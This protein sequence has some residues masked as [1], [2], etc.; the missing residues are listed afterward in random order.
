M[1]LKSSYTGI[2]ILIKV[3]YIRFQLIFRSAG[4]NKSSATA[5]FRALKVTNA[6]IITFPLTRSGSISWNLLLRLFK[7]PVEGIIPLRRK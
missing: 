7:P 1:S 5:M 4:S 6:I 3:P 2:Q